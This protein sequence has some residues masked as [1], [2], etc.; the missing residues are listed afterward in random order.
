[1]ISDHQLQQDV[2]DEL[3][4]EPRVNAAHIGVAAKGGVVTLTGFVTSYTGK[5]AAEAA[6]RRVKGVKAIA[7]EIEVRLPTDKKHADDEIAER[8]VSIL[9]WDELVP[10][11]RLAIKVEN[12]MVTLTGTVDW[13]HQKSEAEYDVRKLSGVVAVINQLQVK[14][15]AAASEVKDQIERALRRNAQLEASGIRIETS[16][17][18][19]TLKG[20]VHDWFERDLIERAAWS[21]P[22]VTEVHD[23]LTVE[24]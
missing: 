20:T 23:R 7:E 17:G 18:S 16:G 2:L 15:P 4:F 12:G 3:E 8:A 5:F 21:V 1:M 11:D 9:H 6:V 24:P 19:V 10:D 22:G 13:Q 14:S